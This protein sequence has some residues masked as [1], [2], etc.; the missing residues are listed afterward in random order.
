MRNVWNKSQD[1]Q[2]RSYYEL[3][4][5]GPIVFATNRGRDGKR[6]ARY[7]YTLLKIATVAIE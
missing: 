3:K 2:S 5:L 7:I 4:R 1:A 6:V